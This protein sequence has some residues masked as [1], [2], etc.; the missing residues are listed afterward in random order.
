[1]EADEILRGRSLVNRHL[2]QKR[3]ADLAEAQSE[4]YEPTTYTAFDT[5]LGLGRLQDTFGNISYGNAQ[6]NGAVGKGETIRLRRGGVLAGYDAM[7]RRKSEESIKPIAKNTYK[8]KTL[9]Y[10]YSFDG[11]NIDI[12]IGGDRLQAIKILS[13][14][15]TSNTG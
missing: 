2:Y 3:I 15:R 11:E 14:A 5:E 12:S 1:M 4:Q 13:I 8:V 9:F 7:P 6:T 10:V